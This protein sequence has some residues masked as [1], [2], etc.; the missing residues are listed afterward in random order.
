[1]KGTI[2]DAASGKLDSSG[3]IKILLYPAKEEFYKR[4]NEMSFF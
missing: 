4:K 1:L 2:I 3:G